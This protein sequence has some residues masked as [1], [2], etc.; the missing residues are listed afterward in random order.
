MELSQFLRLYE[1]FFSYVYI[2]EEMFMDIT[3]LF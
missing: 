2:N 3:I 1:I